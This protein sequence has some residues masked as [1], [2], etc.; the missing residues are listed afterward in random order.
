MTIFFLF[1]FCFIIASLK[2]NHA[3]YS[4]VDNDLKPLQEMLFNN[5]EAFELVYI[6]SLTNSFEAFIQRNFNERKER[7]PP[8]KHS[9]NSYLLSRKSNLLHW[10]FHK[11]FIYFS[12][13]DR[14]ETLVF[15]SFIFVTIRILT[16]GFQRIFHSAFFSFT[17]Q[18][19][20]QHK[21]WQIQFRWKFVLNS[22]DFAIIWFAQ[23]S[24]KAIFIIAMSRGLAPCEF[25]I[26]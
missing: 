14:N 26:K 18:I 8:K 10:H 23:F 15:F 12:L 21:I 22:F 5:F 25:I 7:L 17:Y 16:N 6:L 1:S 4:N 3:I 24:V 20:S 9:K 19:T 11:K 2:R 13:V